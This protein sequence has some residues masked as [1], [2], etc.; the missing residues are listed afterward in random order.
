MDYIAIKHTHM[1]FAIL[2]FVIFNVKG[3]LFLFSEREKYLSYKSKTIAV[4]MLLSVLFLLSGIHLLIQKGMGNMPGIFHLKLT[5]VILS[6][7][8]GIVGFKKE[9][10]VL[11]SLSMA[12][13]LSV[14]LI[15]LFKM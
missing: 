11:V 7:P 15:A 12:C 14:L 4:E 3:L 2:Y 13:I 5:L 10:K 6:I 9:N 8:L 1:A